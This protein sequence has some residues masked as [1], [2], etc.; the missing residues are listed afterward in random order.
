MELENEVENESFSY[1]IK[2]EPSKHR[3]RITLTFLKSIEFS[4]IKVTFNE[5]QRVKTKQG[6]K[7]SNREAKLEFRGIEV[8]TERQSSI[9]RTTNTIVRI[10]MS[11]G[12]FIAAVVLM[13]SSFFTNSL[14]SLSQFIQLVELCVLLEYFNFEFD[15]MIGDFLES[16]REAASSLE[17]L[18]MPLNDWASGLHNSVAGVWKGKLSEV[19]FNAYFFQEVGYAGIIMLVDNLF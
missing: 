7:L 11:V 4:T 18:P 19:D 16:I 1:Q 15:P 8:Q 10:S 2:F 3:I 5:P 6:K 9:Q 14:S 13:I 17:I 12:Y